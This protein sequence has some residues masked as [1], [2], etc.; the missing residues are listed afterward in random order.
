MPVKKVSPHELYQSKKAIAS[1]SQQY[2]AM[3]LTKN[4]TA[5]HPT[6]GCHVMK[7]DCFPPIVETPRDESRLKSGLSIA[8][9]AILLINGFTTINYTFYKNLRVKI[10]YLK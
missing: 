1:I 5:I 9:L 10:K 8:L 3:Q 6:L 2:T 7:I 4:Q